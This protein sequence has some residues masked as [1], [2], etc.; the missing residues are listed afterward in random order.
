[1]SYHRRVAIGIL[2]AY[3]AELDRTRRFLFDDMTLAEISRYPTILPLPEPEPGEETKLLPSAKDYVELLQYLGGHPAEGYGVPP[4]LQAADGE[5]L[6]EQKGDSAPEDSK[7]GIIN[8]EKTGDATPSRIYCLMPDENSPVKAE[9]LLELQLHARKIADMRE[10]ITDYLKEERVRLYRLFDNRHKVPQRKR[11][12]S[13]LRHMTLEADEPRLPEDSDEGF[14]GFW[15]E[16]RTRDDAGNTHWAN[17][18]IT[19]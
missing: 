9:D 1:M 14:W 18:T 19:W 3:E 7:S 15:K 17:C 2:Q 16:R 12:E 6:P 13:N 5:R 10:K 4:V 11:K 8:G